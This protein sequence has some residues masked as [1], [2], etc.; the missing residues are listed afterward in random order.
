M[1]ASSSYLYLAA[2]LT[3]LLLFGA[4][5]PRLPEPI[6]IPPP[7][8][9][10]Q[11]IER[12]NRNVAA[13]GPFSAGIKEWKVS[14]LD[15]QGKRQDHS[16]IMGKLFFRPAPDPQRCPSLYLQ[17]DILVQ[18]QALVLAANEEEF[19]FYSKVAK[20][21]AW[22]RHD[23]YN[24]AFDSNTLLDAVNPI[25]LL[26]LVGLR[27]IPADP[28]RAPYPTFKVEEDYNII[29]YLV[30][31]NDGL[32]V[33]R[34]ITIDRRSDLPIRVFEYDYEGLCIRR[35]YLDK[36]LQL[37]QAKIPSHFRIISDQGLNTFE[38]ELKNI[39]SDPKDRQA[40][41]RRPERI[42]GLDRYVH[43]SPDDFRKHLPHD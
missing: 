24:V 29:E 30:V 19:W 18:S 31:T 7:I 40:L 17:A 9:L 33:R 42:P 14:L 37:E 6:P 4:G 8:T 35:T 43:I 13:I 23:E 28:S 34:Q 10:Y 22:A 2:L 1:K 21:G 11:A 41:F 16:D 27:P 39:K 5:C 32:K 26:E 12:Y 20:Q 15:D 3:V 38:L 36:Y 25:D